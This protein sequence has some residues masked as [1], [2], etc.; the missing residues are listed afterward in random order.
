MEIIEE[1]GSVEGRKIS[2][3]RRSGPDNKNTA[4]VEET[5]DLSIRHSSKL[6]LTNVSN[7]FRKLVTTAKMYC[8]V[9]GLVNSSPIYLQKCQ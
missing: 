9:F 5:E 2:N 3:T 1:T 6:K 7:N 8:V 4:V